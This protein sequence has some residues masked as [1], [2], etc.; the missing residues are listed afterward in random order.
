MVLR[1]ELGA[2]RDVFAAMLLLEPTAVVEGCAYDLQRRVGALVEQLG[3]AGALQTITDM[4]TLLT[5]D[6][7]FE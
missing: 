6:M 5:V 2:D 1:D 4:P 3:Q 7:D